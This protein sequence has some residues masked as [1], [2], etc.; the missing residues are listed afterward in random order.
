MRI[1]YT[2]EQV[3]AGLQEQRRSVV[4]SFLWVILGLAVGTF[5]VN[6]MLLGSEILSLSALAPN[7][8]LIGTVL[9]SMWLNR[10]GRLVAATLVTAGLIL[11]A[12]TAVVLIVGIQSNAVVLVLFFLPL[13]MAGLLL[14][15]LA[16]ASIAAISMAAVTFAPLIHGNL[17]STLAGAADS[18]LVLTVLQF[19]LVFA[20]VTF[21]LDRFGF[22]YQATLRSLLEARVAAEVDVRREKEFS[23]AVIESLPGLFYVRDAEGSLIRWNAELERVSGYSEEE[24]AALGPVGVFDESD[25]PLIRGKLQQIRDA[26]TSTAVARIRTKDGATAP[27]LLNGV[28]TRLEGSDYSVVV[29]ID[30]SE[31]DSA[32]AR[33]DALNVELANRLDRMAALRE[34]DRA[35]IGSLDLN[36]TLSVVLDQVRGRLGAP[37]ARI[38]LYD[39]VDRAL[40]FGASQGLGES[41]QRALRVRLGDGP[42]GRAALE[43]EMVSAEVS[44][45]QLEQDGEVGHLEGYLAVPL[46]AKGQ[47]QGVLELFHRGSTS[48]SD[49]WHDFLDALAT[50]TAI[51]LESASLFEG[52]ERSNIELRQAY[53]TTIEGWSRAL[54]LKDEETEGHSRRV[55]ELCVQLAARYGIAGDQLVH[56]R[57]GA[58]L[59]DIGKMGIPDRI[60]LK[61]GKLD[62]EEWEIMKRHTTYGYE[63]LLSIPFLRPALDIPYAHHERWDGTGYPRGLRGE[64][65]PLSARLFAIVDVF[66][67]LT[68]NRPYRPAW[69]EERALAHIRAES[70]S[71]FDP[72][73][74][75][76]FFEMVMERQGFIE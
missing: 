33:I 67:A 18:M 32:Q 53:D 35:I 47:L 63:L 58:L 14:S 51:A 37:A 5:G 69:S 75:E 61:P 71:H 72:A 20:T 10:R 41:R 7:L 16:L 3:M 45:V 76:V 11:V 2:A 21:L 34:I 55:T 39:S 24:I 17:P 74:V 42:A 48:F 52:L 66:D 23:D 26:G 56:I 15:R 43:R 40:R 50:Q 27:Y 19:D 57:R 38:L 68:S 36:L 22:R 25:E 73:V 1:D 28:R 44:Q 4:N 62:A 65:I 64:Q 46:V 54:D 6:A 49:E 31:I 13:V 59:H 9:L 29:G 30:R 70:G 12:A 60:L 8:L